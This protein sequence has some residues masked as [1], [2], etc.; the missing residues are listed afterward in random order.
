MK[1]GENTLKLTQEIYLCTFLFL[2]NKF[3]FKSMKQISFEICHS[4]ENNF[5]NN[6]SDSWC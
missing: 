4:I 3:P 1:T 2:E 6:C 5:E